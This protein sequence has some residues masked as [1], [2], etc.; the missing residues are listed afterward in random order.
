[1]YFHQYHRF[2]TIGI[3]GKVK[4]TML[5]NVA[6]ELNDDIIGLVIGVLEF[7]GRPYDLLR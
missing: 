3:I 7:S 4:K 1:M 2:L 6:I 5:S